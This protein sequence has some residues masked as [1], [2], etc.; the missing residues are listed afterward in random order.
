MP[1]QYVYSY[2]CRSY[3]V[4]YKVKLNERGVCMNKKILL[5]KEKNRYYSYHDVYSYRNKEILQDLNKSMSYGKNNIYCMCNGKNSGSGVKMHTRALSTGNY[6]LIDGKNNKINHKHDCPKLGE[7]NIKYYLANKGR[8]KTKEE[9]N[10]KVLRKD[11]KEI[12]SPGT[13]NMY[14]DVF[15]LGEAILSTAN[16]DYINKYGSIGTQKQVLSYLYGYYDKG[17]VNGVRSELNDLQVTHKLK[18][19][20]IIFNPKWVKCDEYI[21]K[22]S[23]VIK[24][25]L[26]INK[27]YGSDNY[28]V[29]QY[30]LAKYNGYKLEQDG[31]VNIKLYIKCKK[32]E[33][34]NDKE[35]VLNMNKF[36]FFKRLNEYKIDTKDEVDYFVSAFIYEKDNK[37]LVDDIAFIPVY[38]KYCITV[39]NMDQVKL[40]NELVKVRNRICIK[41]IAKI[42]RSFNKELKNNIPDFII[43]IKDSD[44][45]ILVESFDYIFNEYYKETLLKTKIY[46]ELIKR[47]KYEFFGVYNNIGWKVPPISIILDNNYKTMERL[48]TKVKFSI[49]KNI[50]TEND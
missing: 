38:P 45:V 5:I 29:N 15:Y 39:D 42:D 7:D 44:R 26:E 21:D 34:N 2:I 3:F 36:E 33:G 41:R 27:R 30:I 50:K 23:S 40:L 16:N 37:I 17:T 47:D 1:T 48:Y 14:S 12:L 35:V 9:L 18:L 19:K 28:A 31:M 24:N 10:L 4:E 6:S 46:C 11:D 22:T 43:E 8:I 20:D 49:E 13:F 25:S 32:L